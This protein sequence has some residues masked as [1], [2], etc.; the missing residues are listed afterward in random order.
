MTNLQQG[1][2]DEISVAVAGSF[3][4]LVSTG[5]VATATVVAT[6]GSLTNVAASAIT[7]ATVTAT[8]TV[9]TS[10]SV[11]TTAGS[12]YRQGFTVLG[13]AADVIISGGM[14]VAGSK[15]VSI[16]APA[17]CPSPIG[18]CMATVASGSQPTILVNGLAYMVADA[19][20]TYGQHLAVGAGGALNTVLPITGSPL[21][22][23]AAI[24]VNDAASGAA[25]LVR[26]C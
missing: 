2:K 7:T 26:I 21:P 4:N 22:R 11:A 18:V 1:L 24:A 5:S 6:T 13:P 16:A 12:P 19:A 20:I 25:A 23:V 8:S 10:T 14:W 17:S 3:G 15:T 9:S